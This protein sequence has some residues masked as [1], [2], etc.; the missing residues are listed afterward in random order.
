MSLL[1]NLRE[2][3]L[4][5][6]YFYNI[7]LP[8]TVFSN[9]N[10]KCLNC[11]VL[12]CECCSFTLATA[13]SSDPCRLCLAACDSPAAMASTAS[14][15]R[16]VSSV[17]ITLAPPYRAT[18]TQQQSA[19]QAHST[20]TRDPQC[21]A[22]RVGAGDDVRFTRPQRGDHSQA[23]SLQGPDSRGR[24]GTG[25]S[26]KAMHLQSSQPTEVGPNKGTQQRHNKQDNGTG[27]WMVFLS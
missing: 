7:F 4:K 6:S 11:Q 20:A 27:T 2:S 22:A 17:F 10:F 13:S 18:V 3:I 16:M 14:P 15:K 23:K 8:I 24:L 25:S 26:A 21:S 9:I 19:L 5:K 1:L 12:L